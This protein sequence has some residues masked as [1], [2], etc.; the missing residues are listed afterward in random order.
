MSIMKIV[1]ESVNNTKTLG[2]F[3]LIN[4]Q[5][6]TFSNSFKRDANKHLANSNIVKYR[7]EVDI[8]VESSN[9]S[10]NPQ[11]EEDNYDDVALKGEIYLVNEKDDVDVLID[12]KGSSAITDINYDMD[13][14][15]REDGLDGNITWF[16]ITKFRKI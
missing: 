4:E 15:L 9:N 2:V 8:Q 6:I 7:V 11:D 5:E 16:E 1:E 3:D 14:S 12:L 10:R 13:I